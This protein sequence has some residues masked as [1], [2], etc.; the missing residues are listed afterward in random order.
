MALWVSPGFPARCSPS[1][2]LGQ[3]L[4]ASLGFQFRKGAPTYRLSSSP[5][6][7]G[8]R[9]GRAGPMGVSLGTHQPG[10]SGGEGGH[11]DG[12]GVGPPTPDWHSHP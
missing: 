6:P 10:C 2:A 7:R 4:S 11:A 12:G 1:P 9:H 3:P 8:H 5:L